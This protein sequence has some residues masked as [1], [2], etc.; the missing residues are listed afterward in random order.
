MEQ[1]RQKDLVVHNMTCLTGA[2]ATLGVLIFFFLQNLFMRSLAVMT[3]YINASH[4][5]SCHAFVIVTLA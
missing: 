2:A 5:G 1:A 3:R 4:P